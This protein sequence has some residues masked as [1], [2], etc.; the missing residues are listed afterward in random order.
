MYVV[1]RFDVPIPT[2]NLAAA[3]LFLVMIVSWIAVA[4]CS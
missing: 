3:N 4:N 2:T 1:R